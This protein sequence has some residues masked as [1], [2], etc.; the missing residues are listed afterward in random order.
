MKDTKIISEFMKPPSEMW[1]LKSP[2]SDWVLTLKVRPSLERLG[3]VYEV[4]PR[5][6]DHKRIGYWQMVHADAVQKRTALAAKIM[7]NES[8][9][10]LYEHRN[11]P[12]SGDGCKVY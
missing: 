10:D 11:N 2:N 8:K 4:E 7:N 6:S 5:L 1:Y 12:L 3:R 9:S